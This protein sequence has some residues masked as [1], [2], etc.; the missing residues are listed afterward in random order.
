MFKSER[1]CMQC[2]PRKNFKTVLDKLPVFAKSG[3]T[4]NL[5][6]TVIRIVKQRMI[7]VFHV[8]TN[9]VSASCFQ[10]AFN[11]TNVANSF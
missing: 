3:S 9:L 7:D 6:A 4:Q 2:L 1:F 8:D 10:F 5:V 11:Q